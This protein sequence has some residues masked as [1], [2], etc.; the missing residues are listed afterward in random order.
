M[1][2]KI[3]IV[4]SLL[5]LLAVS[6]SLFTACSEGSEE[7][8]GSVRLVLDTD[9]VTEYE[10]SLSELSGEKDVPELLRY[11]KEKRGLEYD[12]TGTY[13]NSVGSIK[14]DAAANSYIYIYTSVARDFDVSSYKLETEYDGVKLVSSGVGFNE[15][16][17]EDGAIIYVTT[18]VWG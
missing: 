10:V 8:E 1:K 14:N 15:M 13:L 12:A 9:P 11:L 7:T 16:H 6:L 3:L 5:C 2:R 17:L 4:L 18:I